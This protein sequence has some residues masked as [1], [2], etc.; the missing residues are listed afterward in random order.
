MRTMAISMGLA[1]ALVAGCQPPP[2]GN[3]AAAG[4]VTEKLAPE[5]RLTLAQLTPAIEAP[6]DAPD[7]EALPDRAGAIVAE[8]EGLLAKGEYT[9]AISQFERAK[10]FAPNSPRVLRGLGI[11]YAQLGDQAKAL[12]ALRESAK[13]APNHVRLQLLLGTYAYLQRQPAEAIPYFRRALRCGDAVDDN[14][15]TAEALLRL[16]MQ[17][18]QQKYLTAALECYQRLGE[19]VSANARAYTV[20]P[21]LLTIV[22]QPER[23]MVLQGRLLLQLGRAAEAAVM[24]EQGYRRDKTQPDAGVLAV[25]A[26]LKGDPDRAQSIVLEMLQGQ[27]PQAI[28]SAEEFVRVR[29]DPKGAPKPGVPGLG[30]PRKLLEAYVAQG[31]RNPLMVIAM[32]EA[33]VDMGKADEAAEILRKHSAEPSQNAAIMLRLARLYERMGDRLSAGRQLATMLATENA[34]LWQVEP[35]LRRM[36]GSATGGTPVLLVRELAAAAE[37]AKDKQKPALLTLAGALAWETDDAAGAKAMLNKALAADGQFWPAYEALEQ[38]CTFEGDYAAV[39]K[40]AADVN[41]IAGDSFFWYYLV[42]RSLFARGHVEGAISNLEQARARNS[43]HVPTQ[44]LLGQAYL[45]AGRLN[46]AEKAL[47]SAMALAGDDAV[48]NRRVF[49]FYAALQKLPEAWQVVRRFLETYPDSGAPQTRHLAFGD[50]LSGQ[51]MLGRYYLLTNDLT[52]ARRQLDELLAQAPDDVEVRLFQLQM[53]LPEDDV[54]ISPDKARL[55]LDIVGRILRVDKHNLDAHAR[56]AALLARQGKHAESAAE[57]GIVHRR[58]PSDLRV[59]SAYVD[60]LVKAK[61]EDQAAA[62]LQEMA[63]QKDVAPAVR[64]VVIRQL[65]RMKRYPPA[66]ELLEKW[67]RQAEE[68]H[69]ARQEVDLLRYRVLT[70]Y[71]EAGHFDKVQK[72][73]DEWIASGPEAGLQAALKERKLEMYVKAKQFDQA[74]KVLDGWLAEKVSPEQLSLLKVLQMKLLADQGQFEKVQAFVERWRQENAAA[75]EPYAAAVGVLSKSKKYDA[76]LKWA[77]DWL[78]EREKTAATAPAEI[79]TRRLL[80]IKALIVEI[81]VEADRAKEALAKAEAWAK[82]QPKEPQALALLASAY[83]A[84]DRQDDVMNVL[85]KMHA[86]DPDDPGVNNDLGYMYADRG[87]NLDEAEAMIRKALAARSDNLAVIDSFGWLLY[88]QGKLAEAKTV[89][90]RVA[91]AARQQEQPVILDHAGDVLWRMG[92]KDQAIPLWEQAVELG[93]KSPAK[94]PETKRA[95]A[96]SARKVE[97]ARK[98]KPPKIAPLGKGVTVP[99]EK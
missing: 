82:A 42:G 20:R 80:V 75:D 87:V 6:Q 50:P 79:S 28:A 37:K 86:L 53:E 78:A 65:L 72:L 64:E 16:A 58:M 43:R 47:L 25:R 19:M 22:T 88:K 74:Q 48:V 12:P 10:G 84:L 97:T 15:D 95:L 1:A 54:P 98:G 21:V 4:L 14:P 24:L 49:D 73:L 7:S 69:E 61:Q 30:T 52:R 60:A 18:E 39:D 63:A 92:R 40:L 70:V 13:A 68:K 41:R 89:F 83:R 9:R 23:I 17:L 81:L 44:L 26:L 46:D 96:D 66:E 56:Y 33:L 62:V 90:D 76:A 57:W 77:E 32:A 34:G 38:V 99:E 51:V 91:P 8:A 85:E 59:V 27:H 55:A 36:A 29:R 67:L 45:Q 94:D 11:A 93:K 71:E 3:A 5:A 35:E 31:G 2:V